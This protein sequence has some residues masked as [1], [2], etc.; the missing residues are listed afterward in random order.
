LD[1]KCDGL[2]TPLRG[3][4]VC[5]QIFF[6]YNDLVDKQAMDRLRDDQQVTQIEKLEKGRLCSSAST[7]FI[8]CSQQKPKLCMTAAR[9]SR[10]VILP[11]GAPERLNQCRYGKAAHGGVPERLFAKL[12]D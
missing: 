8:V 9:K 6:D 2:K 10:L 7:K 4:L 1:G 5:Y 3:R 11:T 12:E